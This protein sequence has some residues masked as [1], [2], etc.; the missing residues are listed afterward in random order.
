MGLVNRHS[1]YYDSIYIVHD[2]QV[3]GF[4]KDRKNGDVKVRKWD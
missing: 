4:E 3:I 1:L 2:I